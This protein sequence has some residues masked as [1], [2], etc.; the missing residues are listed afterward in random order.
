MAD[1]DQLEPK[2]RRRDG[3]ADD[4]AREDD[5]HIES[6]GGGIAGPAEPGAA[7]TAGGGTAVGG[8]TS[9]TSKPGGLADDVAE[10]LRSA[11]GKPREAIDENADDE[12]G[13]PG[14]FDRVRLGDR[15]HRRHPR[16]ADRVPQWDACGVAAT[17]KPLSQ[18]ATERLPATTQVESR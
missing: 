15:N 2:R 16:S 13:S 5:G 12:T 8:E 18:C 1:R 3:K 6:M 10:A 17:A 14:A 11:S 9:A 4:K 7:G